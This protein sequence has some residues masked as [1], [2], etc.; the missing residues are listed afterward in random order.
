MRVSARVASAL[1]M[2]RS[3]TLGANVTCPKSI[4]RLEQANTSQIT[5]SRVTITREPGERSAARSPHTQCPSPATA[6][7]ASRRESLVHI[8]APGDTGARQE[9]GWR[10]CMQCARPGSRTSIHRGRSEQRHPDLARRLTRKACHMHLHPP[11]ALQPVW[12]APESRRCRIHDLHA[13]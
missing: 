5:T 1:H 10:S 13:W 9:S 8:R 6:V 11:R 2:V 7:H 3:Y 12:L 4:S